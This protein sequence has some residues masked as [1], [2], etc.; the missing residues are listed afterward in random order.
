[1]SKRGDDSLFTP[2][3]WSSVYLLR[4]HSIW[5]PIRVRWVTIRA[6][7][8]ENSSRVFCPLQI[9][10]GRGP[11]K[12]RRH[13]VNRLRTDIRI[14]CGCPTRAWECWLRHLAN[15]RWRESDRWHILP[16]DTARTIRWLRWLSRTPSR[17]LA[18][19]FGHIGCRCR[20]C[21][22][23][24]GSLTGLRAQS[25]S[26]IVVACA[27]D[28]LMITFHNKPIL[29]SQRRAHQICEPFEFDGFI[30]SL[31]FELAVWYTKRPSYTKLICYY[32]NN[33]SIRF[34]RCVYASSARFTVST[35]VIT[36]APLAGIV[37]KQSI[38][39]GQ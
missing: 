9:N 8:W 32:F 1:M 23:V 11:S 38:S 20:Y 16:G 22:T 26:P 25:T 34:W 31:L 29:N 4:S 24:R 35:P 37:I 3:E 39:L 2:W 18:H 12:K 21:D 19:S 33:S 5:E 7:E 30:H 14:V 17:L 6:S 28:C 27:C 36:T 10:S 13:S 15:V